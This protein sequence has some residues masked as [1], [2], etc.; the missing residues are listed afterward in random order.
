[1]RLRWLAYP[2]GAVFLALSAACSDST[3]PGGLP[4]AQVR[5]L[6]G[7]TQSPALDLIVGGQVVAQ[8]V[9]VD[10]ASTF[11]TAP[12]GS[13][14]IALR[15]SGA[16]NLLVTVSATLV[17][18]ARYTVLASGSGT[19]LSQSIAADTG[20]VNPDRANIRIINVV[21]GPPD[22]VENPR[23]STGSGSNPSP[24]TSDTS[25]STPPAL[26]VDVYIT[27]PGASLDGVSPRLSLDAAWPTYSSLLYYDPGTW[28]IR[29]TS[30]GTK[31]VLA[32]T[33]SIAIGAGQ[34]RAV[35]LSRTPGG[36]WD[37]SVVTEQ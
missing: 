9:G 6:N 24:Q 8:G 23:D 14:T 22:P 21:D 16:G 25:T 19:A 17:P 4:T 7:A 3:D 32:E 28:V 34:I 12:S 30:G 10:Q 18:G 29:F 15:A 36:G 27:A 1:M 13:Q 37:T 26:L 5:L 35:K 31:T 33:G 2:A 11:G 20:A